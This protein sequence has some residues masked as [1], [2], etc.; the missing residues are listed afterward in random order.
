VQTTRCI[1]DRQSSLVV[2]KQV[3]FSS[4]LLLSKPDEVGACRLDTLAVVIIL[5]LVAYHSVPLDAVVDVTL[6]LLRRRQRRS[7][8]GTK[9]STARVSERTLSRYHF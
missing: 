3:F 4:S 5:L 7:W 9:V 1:F 6:T 2:K 8:T